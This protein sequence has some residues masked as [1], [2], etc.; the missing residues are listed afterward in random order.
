MK[1]LLWMGYI[2][3][4][5][6]HLTTALQIQIL[7]WEKRYKVCTAAK[8]YKNENMFFFFLKPLYGLFVMVSVTCFVAASM[9]V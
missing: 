4:P 8:I 1:F 9:E 5:L 6:Q 2:S 7:Y 3:F